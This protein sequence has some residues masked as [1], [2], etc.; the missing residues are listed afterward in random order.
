MDFTLVVQDRNKM[1]LL[2][3]ILHFP[4]QLTSDDVLVSR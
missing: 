3:Q 2:L 4:H 1:A